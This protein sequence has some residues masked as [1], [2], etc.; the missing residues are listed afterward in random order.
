[1][2]DQ[3]YEMLLRQDTQALIRLAKLAQALKHLG[4]AAEAVNFEAAELAGYLNRVLDAAGHERPAPADAEPV[5]DGYS[6]YGAADEPITFQ[7][8]E[9]RQRYYAGLPPLDERDTAFQQAL[10]EAERRG[11]LAQGGLPLDDDDD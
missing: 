5:V 2:T 7:D 10:R 4:E 3:S 6:A 1:M 9:R 11:L 8:M